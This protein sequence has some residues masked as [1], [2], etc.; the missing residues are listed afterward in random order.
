[1]HTPGLATDVVDELVYERALR[2]FREQRIV[3]PTFGQLADPT[4]IPA[5][6]ADDVDPDAADP[7]NLFR[8]HWHNSADRRHRVA[9]PAYVVLPRALT[10]VDAAIVVVLADRFPMIASHKVLAAYAC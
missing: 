10:G 3:M 1:M 7:R 6:A 9:V 8:V 4:T 2:R 5:A